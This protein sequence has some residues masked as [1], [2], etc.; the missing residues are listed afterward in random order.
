[1][2]FRHGIAVFRGERIPHFEI[3]GHKR[4]W[5]VLSGAI[6]ALAVFGLAFRGLNLSIDFKGGALL[7]YPLQADVSADQVRTTMA[8]F[9]RPDAQV[10]VVSGKQI[11]V[12]TE[13]LNSLGARRGDL[14]DALAKQAG[15]SAD[16]VNVQD[17]GPTWGKQI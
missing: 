1:M 13:T 5:F 4:R 17:V 14:I 2:N 9:G 11:D 6:I 10:Q 3:I 8:G 12:R 7:E 16:E 15:V